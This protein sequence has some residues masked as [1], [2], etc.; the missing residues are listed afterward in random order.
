LNANF[1]K[2]TLE[3]NL[4]LHALGYIQ[5]RFWEEDVDLHPR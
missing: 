5:W 1:N 4:E 3:L 2:L